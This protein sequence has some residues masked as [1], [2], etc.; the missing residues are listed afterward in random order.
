M[1]EHKTSGLKVYIYGATDLHA[2]EIIKKCQE[3]VISQHQQENNIEAADVAIAPL[4]TT[5]LTEK[6]INKPK[7][8]TLIFH[9]SLLP[10][11]RGADA[12]K[13]AFKLGETYSGVTW[14][15]ADN[16]IDTGDICEQEVTA[17][18]Q[19]EKPREYYER[20]VIPAALRTLKRA[21]SDIEDGRL[22]KV[23]QILENGTYEPKIKREGV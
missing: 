7:Y 22:R 20:A 14:F 3:L 18:N 16:G 21:L 2:P 10:R 8:G 11:H 23:P 1:S 4:L 17:I 15:W 9:P 6:E 19:G 13:W 12:I 5:I